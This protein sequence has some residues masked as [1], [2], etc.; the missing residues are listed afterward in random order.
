MLYKG[1]VDGFSDE[2]I[3][4]WVQIDQ[5]DDLLSVQL[6]F[7]GQLVAESKVGNQRKDVVKP[8]PVFGFRFQGKGKE[9]CDIKN[10]KALHVIAKDG[11]QK[12]FLD[13]WRPI[14][15]ANALSLLDMETIN[16]AKKF[17]PS[18]ELLK[19]GKV[20]RDESLTDRILKN[21]KKFG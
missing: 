11:D 3:S 5:P 2:F 14:L 15:T 21:I 4:G 17:V 7:K 10:L 12:I 8:T 18:S 20:F 13:F 1:V 6:F 16:L 9:W 19:L